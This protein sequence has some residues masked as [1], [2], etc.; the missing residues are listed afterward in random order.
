MQV[1]R[2]IRF[3]ATGVLY[4]GPCTLCGFLVSTDGVND[5][6]ITLY[7]AQAA[8]ANTEVVPTTTFEAPTYGLNGFMP[9]E[10]QIDCPDG[11]YVEVANLGTGEAIAY[12]RAM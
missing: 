8:T 2:A 10:M 11:L 5:P 3:T 4:A 9:G 1:V 7:N 12:V 6:T